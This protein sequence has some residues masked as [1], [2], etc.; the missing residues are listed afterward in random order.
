[1]GGLYL[2][3]E[4]ERKTTVGLY[5]REGSENRPSQIFNPFPRPTGLGLESQIRKGLF[6][7]PSPIPK[8]QIGLPQ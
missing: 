8:A 5:G 7:D 4:A 3:W 1:L 2:D 6:S